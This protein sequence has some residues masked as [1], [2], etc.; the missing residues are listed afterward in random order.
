ME[1]VILHTIDD[2]EHCVENGIYK[3][4][5]L[6]VTHTA[7]NIYLKEYYNIDSSFI[8]EMI[9]ESET[10]HNMELASRIVDECLTHLDDTISDELNKRFGTQVRYFTA[11][12]SYVGRHYLLGIIS[13]MC[14][15]MKI[16]ERHGDI[17]IILYEFL[18]NSMICTKTG[19]KAIIEQIVP[20]D[21]FE[22][23][24]SGKLSQFGNKHWQGIPLW[25]LYPTKERLW[26]CCE[27]VFSRIGVILK[28]MCSSLPKKSIY[29]Y[30]N[31][32]IYSN[33]HMRTYLDKFSDRYRM[34]YFKE[35][36]VITKASSDQVIINIFNAMLSDVNNSPYKN[37]FIKNVR[38]HFLS[39]IDHCIDVIGQIKKVC[40]EHS[41]AL[42]IWDSSPVT[43][44]AALVFEYIRAKG[45][46]ILGMVDGNVYGTCMYQW[47]IYS[48]YSRCNILITKGAEREDFARTYPEHK[49]QCNILPVGL[50]T[51]K[52]G[53]KKKRKNI[54]ILFPITNNISIFSGGMSRLPPDKLTERQITILEYLSKLKNLSVCVKLMMDSS[55]VNCSVMPILK[56]YS[57]L[58][59]VDNCTLKEYLSKY[60]PKIAMVE[61]IASP[62]YDLLSEDTEI[63][64]IPDRLLPVEGKAFDLLK[65]RVHY[66]ENAD[67]LTSMVDDYLVGKLKSKRDNSFY[68]HYEKAHVSE[69]E[70]F[71]ILDD[72]IM[73]EERGI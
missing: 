29:A 70:F 37:I 69:R 67:E 22:I 14:A 23:I 56:K 31:R 63:F 64:F 72:I 35:N 42:S 46:K 13:F 30:S 4:R 39:R 48:T 62:L 6:F 61:N 66:S 38:D 12:Y 18:S 65:R 32:H 52:E 44:D 51:V 1:A 11:L 15:V 53:S 41:I 57:R 68:E 49:F 45:I 21:Q 27:L 26:E 73:N 58:D 24:I 20:A 59:I 50:V 5:M 25:K 60:S 2:A 19:M 43:G 28:K 54:D 17:N 10:R 47:L 36:K 3:G 34:H 55:Y 40:S 8:C 33:K 71:G 9:T 16:R 7:V